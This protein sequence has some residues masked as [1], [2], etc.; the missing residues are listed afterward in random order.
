M[1][2][3]CVALSKK[4]GSCVS[5]HCLRMGANGAQKPWC[6]P[7]WQ[8]E[9]YLVP[10]HQSL[11]PP[12]PLQLAGE[13]LMRDNGSIVSHETGAVTSYA[14]ETAQERGLMFC[15]P[16]DMVR[17]GAARGAE[18]KGC[19]CRQECSWLVARLHLATGFIFPLG[20]APCISRFCYW[21]QDYGG[22]WLSNY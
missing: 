20:C 18:R 14:L 19:V 15:R 16:Q 3:T 2:A 5:G 17:W 1:Q 11:V 12:S 8:F 21:R 10:A 7:S 4:A 6:C 9:F 13:I 22:E